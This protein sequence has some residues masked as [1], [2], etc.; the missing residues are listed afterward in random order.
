MG[1][2]ERPSDEEIEREPDVEA[3]D[4]LFSLEAI[5]EA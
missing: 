3:L 4:L 2:N 5:M 1:K